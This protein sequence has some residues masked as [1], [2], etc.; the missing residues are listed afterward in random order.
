MAFLLAV[1]MGLAADR[2]DTRRGY[3]LAE[4][5]AIHK[6]YLQADYL[7]QPATD[8]M[9]ALLREYIPLRIANDDRAQVLANVQRSNELHKAMWAIQ[10]EVARSGHSPDLVSSFGESLTEIVNLAETRVIAGFYARVPDTILLLLLA[11][12]ALALGMVGYSAGLAGRRS[13]L[14]ALVLIVALAAVL[15]LVI[16]LDRPQEGFLRVSQQP[17]LDVQRL[18]GGG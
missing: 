3:V 12:S 4:A 17:L 6:A 16:D 10:A 15:T 7:P 18:I 1:T 11:G 13:V 2:F 14:G 9:R 8:A 5:N